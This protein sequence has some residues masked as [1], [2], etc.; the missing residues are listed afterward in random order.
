VN[1][2]HCRGCIDDFYND[3]NPLGVKKCWMLDD[4]KVVTRYSIGTWTSPT[5]SGAFT[6]VSVPNCYRE[7]GTHFQD[8]LPEFA[9][10]VIDATRP[11]ESDAR[12]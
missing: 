5:Q 4:A 3:R 9:V 11:E 7:K 2:K 10:G 6:K 1:D 12:A 8:R